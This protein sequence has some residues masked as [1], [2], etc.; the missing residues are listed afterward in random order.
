MAVQLEIVS[1]VAAQPVSTALALALANLGLGS[2]GATS[3]RTKIDLFFH[4]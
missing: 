2:N 4:C 3:Y 1:G